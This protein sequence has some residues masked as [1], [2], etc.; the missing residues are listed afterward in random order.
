MTERVEAPEVSVVER[1]VLDQA[2][3]AELIAL[4]KRGNVEARDALAR[5]YRPAALRLAFQLL[6]NREDARDLTQEAML[7]FF[8]TL[9]RFDQQRPVLPWLRRIVRNG[10]VDLQR[11]GRLRRAE[12]LDSGG[13]EGEAIELASPAPDP[14]AETRRRE[15]QA[16]VWE[17]L[18][19][20]GPSH[21]EILVLRDYQ[22]LSYREIAEIL[23]IP[24]GTVMSRLHAARLKLRD[25][26]LDAGL[27]S[28][29][30]R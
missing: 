30:A 12:S 6:G 28:A 2:A 29:G 17:C 23:D 7:R 14:E 24:I 13:P 26:V 1:L 16:R 22:D 5:R 19:R 21:R 18:H 4:L 15:L 9:D 20:L 25:V 27:M 3:E 11:R 10:A 8:A